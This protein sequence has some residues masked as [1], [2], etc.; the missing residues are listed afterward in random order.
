MDSLIQ[1][2][3]IR[4]EKVHYGDVKAQSMRQKSE[5]ASSQANHKFEF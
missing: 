1:S 3:L 5:S 4:L 2:S